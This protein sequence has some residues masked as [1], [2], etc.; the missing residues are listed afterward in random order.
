MEYEFTI[1]VPVY[2]E[3]ENLLRLEEALKDYLKISLK[4]T[5]I[6]FIND[7][8]T[9]DNLILLKQICQRNKAFHFI[10]FSKNFGLSAA[11]KAGFDVAKSPLIG[12]IVADL[13]THSED[14]NLLLEAVDSF[15]LVT[16]LL[17]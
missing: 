11:I 7:G 10:Y 2:N 13:D 14:L 6:L 8:S 4:K 5:G 12:Y 15:D 17:R 1:I 3:E 9:A 16:V